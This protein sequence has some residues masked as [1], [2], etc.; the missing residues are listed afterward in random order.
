[1][2]HENVLHV[3]LPHASQPRILALPHEKGWMLPRFEAENLPPD[4]QFDL[5]EY[6]M[7]AGALLGCA[8]A[9]L[10]CPYARAASEEQGHHFVFVAENRDAAFE[11]P[12]GARWL[13]LDELSSIALSHEYLLPVIET[14]FRETASGIYPAERPPW[15]FPGWWDRAADW[16]KAQVAANGLRLTGEI[17]LVRKWCITCVIK[18]PTD[19]GDLFFK[20]VPPTFAREVAM[21]GF[22]AQHQPENIP[23]IVASNDAERWLLLR[24]FGGAYLGESKNVAHWEQALRDFA[25]LQVKMTAHV[26]ALLQRGA[27]DYRMDV[28][29]EKLDALFADAALLQPDQYITEEQ[30][31]RARSLVP[32]I[33]ALLAELEAYGIPATLVH[34]DFHLWNTAVQ[35][36]RIIFF[37][38]TD[39]SVA[40]PFFDMALFFSAVKRAE[41]FADQPE[42]LERLRELYLQ[43]LTS[44]APIESLRKALPL[45]EA[46]GYLHQ[47]LNYRHL[48]RSIE[49]SD[50][51]SIN[52]TG[53]TIRRL[54][55][56][57]EALDAENNK[58]A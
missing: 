4:E 52:Y 10:Y 49:P 39:C 9:T 58:T 20:A 57:V 53:F 3:I 2:A 34:S 36:E 15:A 13:S 28:L 45:G 35:E 44:L 8:T 56:Q 25:A 51:W 47:A 46:L 7:H 40:H 31:E 37:D 33:R 50:W 54:L 55:E 43:Q 26:E 1:M 5:F 29:P 18:A 23:A 16:I 19:A 6:G 14:W 17:A 30:L 48:V 42:T 32:R 21:T 22:L 11:P 24:D 38:W 12:E 41:A 27:L